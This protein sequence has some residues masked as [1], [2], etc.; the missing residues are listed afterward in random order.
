[1]RAIPKSEELIDDIQDKLDAGYISND[2]ELRKTLRDIDKYCS[3]LEKNY[4]KGMALA[5][6][7][8]MTESSRYFELSLQLKNVDYARNYVATVNQ[9]S[10]YRNYINLISRFSD[11][12]ESLAFSYLAY[13][14]NLYA[15]NLPEAER[16]MDK[17][18][19]LSPEDNRYKLRLELEQAKDALKSYQKFSGMSDSEL[20]LLADIVISILDDNHA[21]VGAINYV[22]NGNIGGGVNLYTVTAESSDSDLITDMNIQLAFKLAE[23]DEFLDKNFSVFIS[24]VDNVSEFGGKLKW[25]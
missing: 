8:N 9:R 24:G 20:K 10:T 22:T 15:A 25:L 4:A 13:Q 17:N 5:L 1:M 14:A 3:G 19:K 23:H 21:P 6:S 7:N 16:H 18:I 11:E 2:L 12:Y